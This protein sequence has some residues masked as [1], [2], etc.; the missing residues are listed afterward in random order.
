VPFP[1][2]KLV[3]SIPIL[4]NPCSIS[5]IDLLDGTRYGSNDREVRNRWPLGRVWI[6]GAFPS[7]CRN[8]TDARKIHVFRPSKSN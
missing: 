5:A 1:V 8:W 6:V 2:A 4:A 7:F 3:G